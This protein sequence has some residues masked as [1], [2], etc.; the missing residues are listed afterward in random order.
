MNRRKLISVSKAKAPAVRCSFS[1]MALAA[2]LQPNPKNPNKHPAEQLRLY[3]KILLHQ[4]WR[5]PITLSKQGGLIVTGEGAWRTAIAEGWK[6][7]PVDVQEFKT[8]ADEAAHLL[9]DN[10]LPQMAEGDD[11]LFAALLKSDVEGNLDL[12]IAGVLALDGDAEAGDQA[13]QFPIVSQL[14]E[15]HD[16]V[17]VFCDNEMDWQYLQ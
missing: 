5:K 14:L 4:G 11:K 16:F 8:P 1:K 6:Q 10:R 9:A 17:L 15:R 12:E 13:G 3:A 2:E 7:V